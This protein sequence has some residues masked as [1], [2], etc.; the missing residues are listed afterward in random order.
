M[1]TFYCPSK[2]Q[3]AHLA[4]CLHHAWHFE[5][6]GAYLCPSKAQTAWL[7]YC[8]LATRLQARLHAWPYLC[9]SKFRLHAWYCQSGLKGRRVNLTP[10]ALE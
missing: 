9:L 7:A 2:A 1:F 3:A 5:T 10:E 4:Y 6:D 8:F